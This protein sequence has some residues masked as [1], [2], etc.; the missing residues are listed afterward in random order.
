MNKLVSIWLYVSVYLAGSTAP[1][2]IFL[3][4]DTTQKCLLASIVVLFLHLFEEFGYP[5]GFP[6]MGMRILMS[7]DGLDYTKRDRNNLNSMFGNWGFLLLVH[8]LPL[9]LPNVRFLTPSAMPS[10]FAEVFM[11]LVL[12]PIKLKK[13]Y[14]AGQITSVGLGEI[15]CISF[16]QVFDPTHY[17]W[18]DYVLAIACF[19]VA[20]AFR[21]RSKLYWDLGKRPGYGLSGLTAYGAGFERR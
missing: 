21:F 4:L 17:A 15:G 1:F 19:V 18:H 9:L 6:L 12:F 3:P 13:R 10:L 20:F 5:G 14:D 8:V 11:H 2:A 16:A 7:S